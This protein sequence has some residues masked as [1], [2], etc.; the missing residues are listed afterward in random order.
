MRETAHQIVKRLENTGLLESGYL[1]K[2]FF[3]CSR[4]LAAALA[5]LTNSLS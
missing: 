1:Q 5:A 2:R 3:R 4:K